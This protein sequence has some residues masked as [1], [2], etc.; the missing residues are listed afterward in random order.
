MLTKAMHASGI[1][2]LRNGYVVF[3]FP[4]LPD[5]LDGVHV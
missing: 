3:C 2:T 1:E 4:L 5:L